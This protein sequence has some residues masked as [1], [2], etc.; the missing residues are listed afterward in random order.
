M[1]LSNWPEYSLKEIKATRKILQ[2]GKVNYWTG[3]VNKKF[4][5]KF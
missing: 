5:I 4:E 2:S 1:K 3:N